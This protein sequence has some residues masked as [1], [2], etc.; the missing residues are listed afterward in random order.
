L[1]PFIADCSSLKVQDMENL[2]RAKYETIHRTDTCASGPSGRSDAVPKECRG[3]Q[4]ASSARW[5]VS[6]HRARSALAAAPPPVA[7]CLDFALRAPR[8][9]PRGP[10]APRIPGVASVACLACRSLE[11]AVPASKA[12]RE[13]RPV[14]RRRM[15]AS[16]TSRK[17]SS[18]QTMA[19]ALQLLWARGS[20]VAGSQPSRTF[21]GRL[22]ALELNFWLHG[23][24]KTAD[25]LVFCPL[26]AE[27]R[28]RE[29]YHP[30]PDSVHIPVCGCNAE[31]QLGCIDCLQH[32]PAL[33]VGKSPKSSAGHPPRTPIFAKTKVIFS[34]ES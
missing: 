14:P 34:S 30:R 7:E 4:P 28:S 12:R 21:Y 1:R 18:R 15:I 27:R 9:S 23:T 33:S 25:G 31:A 2:I 17:P 20:V 29:A 24:V 26:P 11:G 32:A 8:A 22:C 10:G 19:R 5:T 16:A 6:S 13:C 3:V